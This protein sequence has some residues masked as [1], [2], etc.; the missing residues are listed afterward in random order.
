[1]HV[2]SHKAIRNFCAKHP[3]AGNS[4]DYW[5]RVTKRATWASFADIRQSFNAADFVAPFVVFDVGGN[6]YRL[7]AEIN[8]SRKVLLIR[9]IMTHKEYSK[10]TWKT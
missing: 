3:E 10:G 6:K 2:V 4:L 7:V 5:Y 1:L 9:A 8:F